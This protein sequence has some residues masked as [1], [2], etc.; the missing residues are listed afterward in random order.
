MCTNRERHCVR[1]FVGAC[2]WLRTHASTFG[3]FTQGPCAQQIGKTKWWRCN[4]VAGP[5]MR[6]FSRWTAYSLF[7]CLLGLRLSTFRKTHRRVWSWW[8]GTSVVICLSNAP[9]VSY[10][11]EGFFFFF[12]SKEIEMFGGECELLQDT[13]CIRNLWRCGLVAL[14]LKSKR[15]HQWSCE[16]SCRCRLISRSRHRTWLTLNLLNGCQIIMFFLI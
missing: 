9:A 13:L 8:T 15:L 11:L 4:M 1:A 16:P 12:L 2:V 3:L 10:E 5:E 6:R 7:V 14:L